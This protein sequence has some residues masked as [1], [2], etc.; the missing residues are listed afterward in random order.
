MYCARPITSVCLAFAIIVSTQSRA[1]TQNEASWAGKKVMPRS[2]GLQIGHTDKDGKQVYVAKV[3]DF[4]YTVIQDDTDHILLRHRGVVGWLPKTEAV[5]LSG[6][7]EFFSGR[8][9]S[10][11]KDDYAYAGRGV[12]KQYLG[13]LEGATKDLTEA[14][15]LSPSSSVWR[16]NRGVAFA[17]KK[18]FDRALADFNEAVRLEPK[19]GL[20]F[21]NRASV[22]VT[23]KEFDK[24]IADYSAAILL[25]PK[26]ADLYSSRGIAYEKKKDFEA[27]VADYEKATQLDPNDP[28]TL[29][30]PAWLWATCAK[31]E[32]RNGKKAVE[33]ALKSAKLSE[34]KNPGILDTL[35]AAYAEDGQFELAVKWQKKALEDAE[36]VKENGEE[37][38]VRLKLYEAGKPYREN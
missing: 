30:N 17:D 37:A 4:V 35:A 23:Q 18:D 13:D 34:W 16:N 38:K 1:W 24:A 26:D 33:F 29:N 3:T 12:A 14:V 9:R 6:A 11:P 21:V 10:N 22:Y 5:P 25:D 8:I 19:Y 15:G 31:N 36:Y 27:A 28:A 20:A 2:A 32:V 7:V